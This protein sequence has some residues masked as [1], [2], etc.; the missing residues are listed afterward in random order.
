MESLENPAVSSTALTPTGLYNQNLGGSISPA[1]EPWAVQSGL[2]LGLLAPQVSF[3]ICICHTAIVGAPILPPLPPLRFT[4]H[5]LTSLPVSVS[6]PLP[7]V[8]MNVTS[9]NP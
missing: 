7:P 2:G 9:L 1:L 8:W 3:P 6:L 4:L 5:L